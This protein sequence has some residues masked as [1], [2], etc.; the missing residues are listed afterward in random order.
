M[1]NT[2]T[3]DVRLLRFA[4]AAIASVLAVAAAHAQSNAIDAAIEGYV[5]D[6]SGGAVQRAR[7]T[8]R[9]TSTNVTSET[10]SNADGYFRFPL[11][12]VGSY[13]LTVD[14]EGFKSS[15]KPDIT[16]TAGQKVRLDF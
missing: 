14:A 4:F 9:N 15:T 11:L 12:Q 13:T 3:R 10:L 8:V 6:A 7:L 5:R 1:Q 2:T 16:L